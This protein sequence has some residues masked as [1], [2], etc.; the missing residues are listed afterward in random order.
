MMMNPL[1]IFG[2]VFGSGGIVYKSLRT[3]FFPFRHL[4]KGK[5]RPHDMYYWLICRLYYQYNVVKIRR[6]SPTW[7]D[8]T[9]LLPEAIFQIFIDFI[10]KER[11][12]EIIDTQWADHK[13]K[14][15][16]VKE[17]YAWL[18]DLPNKEADIERLQ[19]E[20]FKTYPLAIANVWDGDM[21]NEEEHTVFKKV[22][23]IEDNLEEE[24]TQRAIEIL[25]LR[26]LLW[27]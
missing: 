19:D 17:I 25:S 23:D 12:L 18:K 11:P 8:P 13:D 24:K 5:Y 9:E 14:W 16:K 20:Y 6:L 7:N 1:H 4:A 3:I 15:D 22:V 27:L 2:D 26:N 21:R 10:E